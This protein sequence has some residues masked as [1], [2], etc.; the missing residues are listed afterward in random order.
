M[1][2][3]WT[4]VKQLRPNLVPDEREQTFIANA[5][6]NRIMTILHTTHSNPY[7]VFILSFFHYKVLFSVSFADK[8]ALIL[9]IHKACKLEKNVLHLTPPS[10]PFLPKNFEYIHTFPPTAPQ[11]EFRFFLSSFSFLFV[12]SFFVQRENEKGGTKIQLETK[13]TEHID[14]LESDSSVS[15]CWRRISAKNT[16]IKFPRL[17]STLKKSQPQTKLFTE[18]HMCRQ[19]T[20]DCVSTTFSVLDSAAVSLA[21]I[22]SMLT[23]NKGFRLI[24]D[25]PSPPAPTKR[26]A[27]GQTLSFKHDYEAPTTSVALKNL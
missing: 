7:V 4:A 10:V 27:K 5:S 8:S 21:M 24:A 6:K 9:L 3:D 15:D 23:A 14:T 25:K 12:D 18:A 11:P 17:E 20:V 19:T 22:S 26:P 1:Q 2:R 16:A 13:K